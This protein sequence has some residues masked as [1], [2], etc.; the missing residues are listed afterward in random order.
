LSGT[1]S[2]HRIAFRPFRFQARAS[3][4]AIVPFAIA[5]QVD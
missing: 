5:V 3:I 1:G 4:I 2:P